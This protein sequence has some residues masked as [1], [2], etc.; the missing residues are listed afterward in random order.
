MSVEHFNSLEKLAKAIKKAEFAK[1]KAQE[2][3]IEAQSKLEYNELKIQQLTQKYE[4]KK[5]ELKQIL[6]NEVIE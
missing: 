6:K 4:T 5:N 2:Q 3:L 1:T